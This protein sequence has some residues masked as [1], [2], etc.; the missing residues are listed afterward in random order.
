MRC[1][2]NC[3]KI[4]TVDLLHY[5]TQKNRYQL[6]QQGYTCENETPFMLQI[7]ASGRVLKYN[8]IR[9]YFTWAPA[10]SQVNINELSLSV[11]S[12]PLWPL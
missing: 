8:N 12:G 9:L 6:D 10:Q 3:K 7:T 4:L 2:E 5:H 1:E 11:G